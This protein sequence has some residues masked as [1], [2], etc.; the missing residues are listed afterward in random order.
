L[1]VDN[2]PAGSGGGRPQGVLASEI[3]VVNGLKV[4]W[5]QKPVCVRVCVCV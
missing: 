5:H 3:S 1:L 4:S 2:Y